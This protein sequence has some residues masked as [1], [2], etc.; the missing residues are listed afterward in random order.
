MHV[1]TPPPRSRV[2]ARLLRLRAALLAAALLALIPALTGCGLL[3]D[4]L[5]PDEIPDEITSKHREQIQDTLGFFFERGVNAGNPEI[6]G[7]VMLTPGELGIPAFGRMVQEIGALQAAELRYGL[8]GLGRA[9][10]DGD[11]V[12]VNARTNFGEVDFEVVR[13][14]GEWR[15]SRVPALAPDAEY[16][17]YAYTWDVTND[18]IGNEGTLVVV[19]VLRNSGDTTLLPHSYQ[20]YIVDAAGTPVA[21]GSSAFIHLPFVH[22]GEQTVIRVDF[23][24][25]DGYEFSRDRLGFV[26]IMRVA[27]PTDEGV[28]GDGVIV[29]PSELSVGDMGSTTD[30]RV[31]NSSTQRRDAFALL[32]P[33]DGQGRPLALFGAGVRDLRGGDAVTLEIA[34]P[35]HAAYARADRVLVSSWATN[36]Q[37]G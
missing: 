36:L 23:R 5:G 10:I 21:V 34:T 31:T 27:R 11:V 1:H 22:P 18:Y 6:A 4:D 14:S 16:W 17:P 13:R 32:T 24:P 3:G 7:G 19:G 12:E 33:V 35:D 9:Q 26:P 29:T 25:P 8:I 28:L 2:P 30:I 37:G 20:G 15:I